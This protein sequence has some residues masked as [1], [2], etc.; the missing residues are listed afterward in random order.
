MNNKA[1]TLIEILVAVLIIGI[2]AAIAV[3][4]YKVAVT[5]TKYIRLMQIVDTLW[6]G[7]Q[8]Y[9]LA[10]G[11]YATKLDA[12]DISLPPGYETQGSDITY[13]WVSCT[14]SA[15]NS[16]GPRVY[17]SMLDGALEYSRLYGEQGRGCNAYRKKSQ[18]ALAY[19]VCNS[20]GKWSNGNSTADYFTVF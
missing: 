15:T 10:N 13:D 17:C 11:T 9:F 12:L 7:Q 20:I 18:Y 19:R 3:P 14:N 1:F 2:L 4:Q 8:D 6:R 5:R 16:N